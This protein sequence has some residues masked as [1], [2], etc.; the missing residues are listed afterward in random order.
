MWTFNKKG[1]TTICSEKAFMLVAA[2]NPCHSI[3]YKHYKDR[4]KSPKYLQERT[5]LRARGVPVTFKII[6]SKELGQV[7]RSRLHVGVFWSMECPARM[8]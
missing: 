5:H 6:R 2:M 1:L 7:I 4:Y 3:D 8:M